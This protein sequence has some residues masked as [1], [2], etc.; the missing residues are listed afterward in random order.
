MP[1]PLRPFSATEFRCKCGCAAGIERMHPD[2]LM[3]LDELRDRAGIPLVLS[4]A[5]RC[6]A[7]NRKVGG[8]NAS[9]HTR[10]YAVD[11]KCLNSHT[12]FQILQAALEAGF[13][14]IE[15]APTWIHVDTD[16]DKPFD[17]AFYQSGGNY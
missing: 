9:A 17:V 8:V 11:I 15:L 13:R 12:R 7:H 16:P 3:M 1:I 5:Y 14:R 10:G 4:S 6:E 2:L